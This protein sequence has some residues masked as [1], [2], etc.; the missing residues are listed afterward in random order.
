[1]LVSWDFGSWRLF[2]EHEGTSFLLVTV[3]NMS[4]IG[5]AAWAVFSLSL[6]LNEIVISKVVELGTLCAA[7]LEICEG[8]NV[9]DGLEL[10]TFADEGQVTSVDPQDFL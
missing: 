6:E 10:V 7:E 4:S 2:F 8:E 5:H 3:M 9:H 1:M